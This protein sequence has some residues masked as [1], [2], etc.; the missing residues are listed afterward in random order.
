LIPR[1]KE[2]FVI[3]SEARQ[4]PMPTEI[5]SSPSVPRK[6]IRG[7]SFSYLRRFVITEERVLRKTELTPFYVK[8]PLGSNSLNKV[9][10]SLATG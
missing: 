3:A 6:D 4:S 2:A 5:A 1:D 9:T 8:N 10:S 7:E